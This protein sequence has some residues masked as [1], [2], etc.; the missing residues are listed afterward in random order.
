MSGDLLHAAMMDVHWQCR[1][2]GRKGRSKPG[3]PGRNDFFKA[4]QHVP[5]R[6]PAAFAIM[7]P[8][9][10]RAERNKRKAGRRARR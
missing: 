6:D 10:R 4:L 2:R 3:R 8:S 5:M 1:A 7:P 9:V